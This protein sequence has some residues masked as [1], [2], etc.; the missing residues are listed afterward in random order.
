MAHIKLYRER[1]KKNYDELKKI[2][3]R[4]K[5]EWGIVTKLLCG[6]EKF[7]EEVINLGN[8]ELHDSRITNL[9]RI[10]KINNEIQTVYIKPPA[11]RY[12]KSIV[13]FADVSLNTELETILLLNEEARRQSKV[14]KIII[15]IELG[16][17]REGILG[18][19]L[20]NF[21]SKIFELKNIE[22]VG[23]GSNFNCLNGVMPSQDKLIQLSLYKSLLEARFNKSIPFVSGGSTVVLPLIRKKTVPK[24]INHFRIGEALY[25]GKDLMSGNTFSNMRDDVFELNAQIIELMKKPMTPFGEFGE[26][27]SGDMYE[28]SEDEVVSESYRAI[29]DVGLL[30]VNPS[31]IFPHDEAIKI[32]GAS[33]DMIV[34]DLGNNKKKYSVGDDLKFNLKYMGALSLIN[35]K[36][37]DKTVS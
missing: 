36:Y 2:L 29:I 5:I 26:N 22:I 16:D 3:E 6:N 30:D 35:S 11:K 24:S 37:I 14:H 8:L 23:L 4:E 18:S 32:I 7:L 1:L 28:P 10:K 31:F 21:Y 17:L 15:M 12:V 34:L 9:K 27:P 33:S 20:E 13:E 19:E 25:F